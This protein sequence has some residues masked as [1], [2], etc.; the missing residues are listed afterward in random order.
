M[1]KVEV[2]DK[3]DN[4][5]YFVSQKT[6]VLFDPNG[7]PIVIDDYRKE[8]FIITGVVFHTDGTT[9]VFSKRK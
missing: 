3:V 5:I 6:D 4:R 7:N 2:I 1:S 8:G 9:E